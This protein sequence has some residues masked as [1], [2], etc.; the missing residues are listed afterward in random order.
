MSKIL[1][2]D[3]LHE[4]GF[5]WSVLH[6]FIQVL[7]FYIYIQIPFTLNVGNK[8]FRLLF[9]PS[10][11]CTIKKKLLLTSEILKILKVRNILQN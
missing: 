8:E 3:D 5:L 7:L 9:F 2:F 6:P 1:Y 10:G 4:S 11:K